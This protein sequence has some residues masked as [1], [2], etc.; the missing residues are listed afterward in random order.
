MELHPLA[1]RFADVVGEYERG[2][3]EY[4]P[5]VVG[6]IAAELGVPPGEAVL[7]LAAGTGKFARALVGIGMDVIA[8]EPQPPL[9]EI[10]AASIGEEHVRAGFAEAI[11][12]ADASVAAVTV[13][14]ARGEDLAQRRL[15]LDRYHV[16]V[17]AE[18]RTRELARAGRQIEK[19]LTSSDAQLRR[20]RARDS[21]RILRSPTL[22]RAGDV[23]EA[24]G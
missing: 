4:P 12:L 24:R 14:D 7:D 8:V 11:P 16:Q 21:G 22:I 9:R 5:A 13:A 20:D 19:R 23:G 17:D 15:R 2:R 1:A 10:L 3:P 18:Q 6:A